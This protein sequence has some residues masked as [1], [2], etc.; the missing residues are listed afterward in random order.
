MTPFNRHPHPNDPA[1][2]DQV[3]TCVQEALN[4]QNYPVLIYSH[5]EATLW[6]SILFT[7]SFDAKHIAYILLTILLHD[8]HKNR[9][10]VNVHF[11]I[12]PRIFSP[13]LNLNMV[14]KLTYV[15]HK[16]VFWCLEI[17]KI[18][19]IYLLLITVIMFMNNR[20]WKVVKVFV[21]KKYMF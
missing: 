14:R 19:F 18:G 2:V 17:F 4:T 15:W 5:L 9:W 11:L 6:P 3:S 10:N 21:Y 16:F 20:S 7:G 1:E 13:S 12:K 8:I